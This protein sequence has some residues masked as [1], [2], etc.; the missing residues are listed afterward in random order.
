MDDCDVH[1]ANH[2]SVRSLKSKQ[3]AADDDNIFMD[4][5]RIHHALH[6]PNVAET[7]DAVQFVAWNRNDEGRR[8]R[9]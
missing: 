3:S 1:A 5:R 6:I 2:Q 7:D 8:A 9:R 4:Q